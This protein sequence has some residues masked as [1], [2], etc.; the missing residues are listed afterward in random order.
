M[1]SVPHALEKVL[2]RIVLE[3]LSEDNLMSL[4]TYSYSKGVASPERFV[5]TRLYFTSESHLHSIL[6]C[7]EH[8]GLADAATDEQWK[9]AMDYVSTVPEL[10][11]LSQVVIMIYEDPTVEPKTEKKFH[12]ELHFSPG[13]HAL[14]RD[15]PA[16]SGFRPGRREIL[17]F[18][19]INLF[20]SFIPSIPP[21]PP[22]LPP[23][24]SLYFFYFNTEIACPALLYLISHPLLL[25]I[26]RMCLH[27]HASNLCAWNQNGCCS[28]TSLLS[29]STS[30]AETSFDSASEHAGV[31]ATSGH[32][33][34]TAS[35]R[36]I[37]FSSR[38]QSVGKTTVTSCRSLCIDRSL[39]SDLHEV[40][41]ISE[42]PAAT[43]NTTT[44]TSGATTSTINK[45]SSKLHCEKHRKSQRFSRQT[46]A[47]YRPKENVSGLC[48]ANVVNQDA[49]MGHRSRMHELWLD[50]MR[51]LH[52]QQQNNLKRG[53]ERSMST[54]P[55]VEHAVSEG[56]TTWLEKTLTTLCKPPQRALDLNGGNA[57]QPPSR[58]TSAH[59]SQ[60][61]GRFTV[62]SSQESSSSKPQPLGN[63][64]SPSWF[65]D[66][67]DLDEDGIAITGES[68]VSTSHS[69]LDLAVA[70]PL[71]SKRSSPSS[72]SPSSKVEKSRYFSATTPG[73]PV[74]W[75]CRTDVSPLS[76]ITTPISRRMSFGDQPPEFCPLQKKSSGI[77]VESG[78]AKEGGEEGGDGTDETSATIA[79]VYTSLD[80]VKPDRAKELFNQGAPVAQWLMEYFDQIEKAKWNKVGS[81]GD[82][83]ETGEV[84]V[85]VEQQEHRGSLKPVDY[86]PILS[87]ADYLKA[88]ACASVVE[89]IPKASSCHDNHR[90][91][92]SAALCQ[93][94]DRDECD[95]HFS[96]S[97]TSVSFCP[98]LADQT[99]PSRTEDV[100]MM[101]KKPFE[102]TLEGDVEVENIP[103]LM[104]NSVP[105]AVH[106][107]APSDNSREGSSNALHHDVN[108]LDT[109]ELNALT[110]PNYQMQI[111]FKDTS[112]PCCKRRHRG[113]ISTAVIRGS[114]DTY[115]SS[116]P[117]LV[118]LLN[119]SDSDG[120]SQTESMPPQNPADLMVPSAPSVPEIYPLETLHNA[121]TLHQ[122]ESFFTRLTTTKFPSPFTSP[123][124]S[125]AGAGGGGV[126]SVSSAEHVSKTNSEATRGRYTPA[127]A[128]MD[129]NAT[130]SSPSTSNTSTSC[131][132]HAETRRSASEP[133]EFVTAAS[134][135]T[136]MKAASY[137]SE[138]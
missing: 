39:P 26:V 102:N 109:K 116:V 35:S 46:S 6:T 13:A 56:N 90:G 114:R 126:S 124:L 62:T 38:N 17:L 72:N 40:G 45:V 127:P 58:P 59:L 65:T 123:C 95:L 24:P 14:C 107:E 129:R 108:G 84:E 78:G 106:I 119:C 82:E 61:H 75:R 3:L 138:Q 87:A 103:I 104:R 10:N 136:V 60:K 94:S 9:R 110:Y 121:M 37:V 54:G 69:T 29:S 111:D 115:S 66:T 52:R 132:T 44:A 42:P 20:F 4:H 22:I 1:K 27:S 43:T 125:S 112:S 49:V 137:P 28:Q 80:S 77:G 36:K 92:N 48:Y 105:K 16:G 12:V 101:P 120:Q 113:L 68:E 100:Q 131:S 53:S 89:W 98:N 134:T 117:D 5:R 15:L 50:N 85:E 19:E 76:T 118:Q 71:A 32:S 93:W 55:M 33:P 47:I 8:G 97:P 41:R 25:H 11:Y 23:P 81:Q 91:L 2:R 21:S 7:L 96:I 135:A 57:S 128:P 73:S 31:D 86:K 63:P 130:P 79:Q 64:R 67:I 88:D 99:M 74:K 133:G 70:T 18:S 30:L 83:D 122:L 51:N 34:P